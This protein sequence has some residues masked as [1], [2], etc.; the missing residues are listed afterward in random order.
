M[1]VEGIPVAASLL[2][3]FLKRSEDSGIYPFGEANLD[4]R[5][6]DGHES[7]VHCS[8]S[9]AQLLQVVR[10]RWARLY[11]DSCEQDEG[12]GTFTP[13]SAPST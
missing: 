3:D 11:Q 6:E 10:E 13:L 1:Q 4:I 5:S 9:N 7:D 12:E 2:S 8:G